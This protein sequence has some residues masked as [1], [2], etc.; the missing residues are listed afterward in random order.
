M[1][2]LEGCIFSQGWQSEVGGQ[3]G[4]VWEIGDD[5]WPR[6]FEVP[7]KS[8]QSSWPNFFLSR[9]VDGQIA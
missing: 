8:N 2:Q 7:A 5:R 4:V 3:I 9:A 1:T 6:C